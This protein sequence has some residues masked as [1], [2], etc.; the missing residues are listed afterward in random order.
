MKTLW[1]GVVVGLSVVVHARA[2]TNFV[3]TGLDS[4]GQNIWNAPQIGCYSVEWASSMTGPWTD[5]WANL[6]GMLQDEGYHT[7]LVPR[8]FRLHGRR[9]DLLLHG[10]GANGST[11]ITDQSGH[12][13]S[14]FGDTHITTSTS[15]FGGASISFDGN[16]DYL[17]IPKSPDWS[18]G[19]GDFTVSCWI[20]FHDAVSIHLIGAH[21][22]GDNADWLLGCNGGLYFLIQGNPAVTVQ[23]TPI[24]DQWYHLAATRHGTDVHLFV[25]G[26]LMASGSSSLNIGSNYPLTI[27]APVNATQF[28]NGNMDEIMVLK[29]NALWTTNF[30]PPTHAFAF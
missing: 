18:F 8:F 27:G 16:G 19:I 9:A 24:I 1:F 15:K 20:R 28:F 29:G 22:Y 25:D 2:E 13:V 30:V 11:N 17:S 26:Q 7:N 14:V 12:N 4:N 23:W 6:S 3:I 21:Q 10:D 5:T